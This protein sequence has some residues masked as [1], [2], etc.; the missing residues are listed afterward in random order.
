M[1]VWR[2]IVLLLTLKCDHATHLMSDSY[3]R[4]LTPVE[5]WALRLHQISCRYCRRVARQLRLLEEAARRRASQG[6]D[7]SASARARIA[8]SLV[9]GGAKG[10]G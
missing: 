3:L 7:L 8:A 5:R 10:D 1:S 9:P 4:Q 6:A 2:A